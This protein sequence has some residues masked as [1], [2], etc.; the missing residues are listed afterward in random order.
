[1]NDRLNRR[2]S[3]GPVRA[4]VIIGILSIL[5]V[6]SMVDRFTLGLLVE[7]LKAD[8]ELSDVQVGLLIG[9]AFAIFYATIT[10]PLARVADRGNRVWLIACGVLLWSA[11]TILSGFTTSFT[12]LIMLRVGLAIGEA[13]LT[14]ATF[15][16]IGD[17]LPPNRRTFG[18][19]IFNSFGMAGASGAYLIGSGAIAAALALQGKGY[20]ASQATWQTVL[21]LVGCPGLIL[22]LF[23]LLIARD[24]PRETVS[25]A[26]SAAS[27]MDVLRYMWTK[28]WLYP[29]LYL[30]AA[31]MQFGINGFLA[32]VPTYLSRTYGIS[33]IDAGRLFG[34]YNVFAFI[35][36][37][38]AVPVIGAWMA[39]RRSDGIFLVTVTCSIL[40]AA[41]FVMSVIQSSPSAFLLCTFLGMI[42]G[43]GAA[44]NIVASLH[45]YS[46]PQM[47]ATLMAGLLMCYTGIG[48]GVAPPLVGVLST[49]LAG[50]GNPLGLGLGVVACLG[51]VVSFFL[52]FAARRRLI[53]QGD[54]MM[55]G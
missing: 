48:L 17:L 20:F 54:A 33:A 13:A 31:C 28:G 3:I 29:G 11:S 15:S 14:P 44:S 34:T 2:V 4:W 19:A 47:R 45:L 53:A 10:L 32:W 27:F 42:F 30:G 41:F 22:I 50:V 38:F 55:A 12:I 8:L 25:G 36:G 40:S 35:L 6:V 51:G 37:S 24:P 26:I 23:F 39:R 5:F 52:L 1:M 16:L 49:Q 9:P 21:I 18:G 46:P 43:V 7:P